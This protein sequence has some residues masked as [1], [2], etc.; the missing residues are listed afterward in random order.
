MAAPASKTPLL[1]SSAGQTVSQ[2]V[3][4][5]MLESDN[6]HAEALHRLVGI[7][8]GYG[9]TW[10]AAKSG[11]GGATSGEGLTATALYDGSGLSRSDRLTGLQLA[12]HRDQ[13]LRARQ[14]TRLAA[15]AHE[16]RPADRGQDRDAAGA[17]TAGSRALPRSAPSAR[18][19]PR[20]APSATSCRLA[21]WT[22]GRD[23]RVKTFAFVVNG[24]TS[25][26][27]LRQSIDMLAATVNG[28][29]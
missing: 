7:K 26:L 27:A 28:C 22:V 23:G 29:Y 16:L 3:S 15:A 12:Q 21:G 25:T 19:T 14:R 2:I 5:M 17:P 18:S 1:A 10:A 4:R 11:P 8:L 24:R 13:R 20:P 9:N 6:E